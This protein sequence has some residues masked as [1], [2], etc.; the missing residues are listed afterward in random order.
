MTTPKSWTAHDLGLG[1]LTIMRRSN[2][3][4]IERRYVFLDELGNELVGV[5]GSR[6]VETVAIPDI[7]N[8]IVQALLEIDNWTKQKALEQEGMA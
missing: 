1:K 6:V 2:D 8:D 7:P 5:A 4:Q 3:L